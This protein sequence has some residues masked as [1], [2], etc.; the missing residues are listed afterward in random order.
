MFSA[1]CEANFPTLV[2]PYFC[3]SHLAS[4]TIVFWC[5][6]GGVLGGGGESMDDS[7]GV[8][9]AEEV[10]VDGSDILLHAVEDD[11]KEPFGTFQVSGQRPCC[12]EEMRRTRWRYENF[13][14]KSRLMTRT[15]LY[16]RRR[17]KQYSTSRGPLPYFTFSFPMSLKEEQVG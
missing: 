1:I 2:P 9:S 8:D 5:K 14:K 11:I 6:F 17:R 13:M 4:G 16:I 15:N 7:E 12:T 3:T 10:G